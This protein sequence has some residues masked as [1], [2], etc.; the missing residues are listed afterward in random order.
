MNNFLALLNTKE[1]LHRP[2]CRATRSPASA[3]NTLV[4]KSFSSF[5]GVKPMY[6]EWV[7]V[8]YSKGAKYYW[9]S[10]YCVDTA[11]LR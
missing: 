4:T 6:I 10:H 11:R 2:G 7:P 8:G 1:T 3:T 5:Q 9:E